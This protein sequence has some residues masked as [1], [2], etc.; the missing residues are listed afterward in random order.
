MGRYREFLEAERKAG[1][2]RAPSQAEKI[3]KR[4]ANA[5]KSLTG[6]KSVVFEFTGDKEM[7]RTLGK[8][9]DSVARKVMKKAVTK[10]IRAIAKEMKNHVPTQYKSAKV[11]FGSLV[12][13]ATGGVLKARAG[14]AVGDA[15]KKKARRSKG[16]NKKGV[17]ISA[18][19]IH[20]LILGT[21]ER[22][23]K[24]TQMYRGGR[25]VPVTNWPTGEMPALMKD[26]V[27]QGF[28]SGQSKAAEIIRRE[29]KGELARVVPS[30]N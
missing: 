30:G 2:G 14:S 28:A 26:V 11:L 21:K 24:R 19:N 29:L 15:S 22:T 27:R 16:E 9:R 6:L 5:V 17:G 12:S 7:I 8:V 13:V 25:L 18:A 3:A 10:G 1:R 4:Q 20:W 23:V